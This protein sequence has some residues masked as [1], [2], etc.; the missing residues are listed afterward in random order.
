MK[1]IALLSGGHSSGKVAIEVVRRF[2]KE[3]VI[4]LNHDL[5]ALVEA[6]DIKR[7]KREVAAYVGLPITYV[8]HPD[9]EANQFSVCIQAQAFKVDSGPELCTARLKTEPFMRYLAAQ[10]PD[11][12]CIIYYGYDANEMHRVQR[13][14]GVLGPLGYKTDYPLALWG[15]ES[16]TI[17]STMEVGIAPPMG[18]SQFKHANC[19]GCLKAGWQHWYIVYCTRP[20]IW[21]LGKQAEDIIGYAIHHDES[22][23]VYMEDMEEKFAAMRCAGVPQTEH[24]PHQKFW[25]KANKIVKISAQQQSILPCECST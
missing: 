14:I 11:K 12:D 21:A 13:R 22:G 19:I 7:F 8:N 1:H 10:F 20:D 17:F 15:A 25:A 23:P 5:P 24:I 6:E 18:Y 16:R 9:P 3:N 4:L 2:G